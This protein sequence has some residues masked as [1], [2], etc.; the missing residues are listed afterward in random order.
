MT[1]TNHHCKT[2]LIVDDDDAVLESMKLILEDEGYCVNTA[3]DGER[4]H[5]M[6][7]K[8]L[9]DLIILDYRLPEKSGALLAKEL[10]KQQERSIFLLLWSLHMMLPLLQ[11]KPVL[12][13]F[14]RNHSTSKHFL[15]LSENISHH[16]PLTSFLRLVRKLF[17][18]Y[19]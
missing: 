2:V 4:M 10:K 17:T 11:K 7:I 9:P 13:I 1:S 8:A 16:R 6:I 15:R 19:T 12:L 18:A 14:L 5:K 3:V